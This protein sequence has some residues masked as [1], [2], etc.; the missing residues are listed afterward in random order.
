[1]NHS[2]PTRAATLA[3]ALTLVPSAVLAQADGDAGTVPETTPAESRGL[4]AEAIEA[5][6][7]LDGDE[8]VFSGLPADALD[9]MRLENAGRE[10]IGDVEAVLGTADGQV[11][12]FVVEVYDGW[13]DLDSR[14][15]VVP[16]TMV[17]LDRGREYLTTVMTPEEVSGLEPWRPEG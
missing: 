9:D 2:M 5:L 12:G 16:S 8:A 7:V 11:R 4:D 3:L 10:T 14:E 15:V 13:T 6:V 17:A 1:M